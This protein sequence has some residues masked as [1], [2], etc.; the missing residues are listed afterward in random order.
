VPAIHLSA[1]QHRQGVFSL[2]GHCDTFRERRNDSPSR[3]V[4][5]SELSCLALSIAGS[6][7]TLSDV[8]T[9]PASLFTLTSSRRFR[10]VAYVE[11]LTIVSNTV[12]VNQVSTCLGICQSQ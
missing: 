9:S 6:S 12:N 10:P 4:V 8:P 1:F 5:L 7:W 2:V 11:A 3:E